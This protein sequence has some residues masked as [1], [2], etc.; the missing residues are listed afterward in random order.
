M[1]NLKDG[2]A[3]AIFHAHIEA[4]SSGE[5]KIRFEPIQ[6]KSGLGWSILVRRPNDQIQYISGFEAEIDAIN[7]MEREGPTWNYKMEQALNGI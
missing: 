4:M 3:E 2:V 5:T 7:W 6:T 1:A